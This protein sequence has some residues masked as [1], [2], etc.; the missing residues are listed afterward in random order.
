MRSILYLIIA[1][2]L[3]GSSVIGQ[4]NK[5]RGTNTSAEPSSKTVVTVDAPPTSFRKVGQAEI[6]YFS[7]SDTTEVRSEFSGYRSPGQSATLWFVFSTRDKRVVQPKMVSVS[8][9][10]FGDKVIVENL[11]D[12]AL[13]VDGK[14]VQTDDRRTSGVGFDYRSK[15][16]FKDMKG[17]IA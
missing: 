12:F 17:T 14:S 8:M 13:E 3:A 6:S 11:R 10:L 5:E 7:E 2:L 9:A 4:D 15:L 1:L 16:S